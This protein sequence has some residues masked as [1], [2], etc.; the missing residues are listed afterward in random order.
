M[1]VPW[2]EWRNIR[3][4]LIVFGR[5]VQGVS[6]YRVLIEPDPGRCPSGYC[7][8]CRREIAANPNIS[9]SLLPKEQYYLTKAILVHEAGHRRFTTPNKLSPL[10]HQVANIL[11]DE[12]IERQMCEEFAGVRWL[13]RRLSEALYEESK[14]VDEKSDSPGE[15][16]AYFLQLRWAK[17]IG[18]PIKGGLS[19]KE[20]GTLAE[21]GTPSL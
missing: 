17:R 18:Q 7:N 21:G 2:Y 13:V 8:F 10:V 19:S 14:P 12:R 6:P 20:S 15:V 4:R 1:A 3:N 9:H 5:A 11:E 16:V